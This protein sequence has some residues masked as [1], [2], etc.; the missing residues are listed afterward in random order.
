MEREVANR[1]IKAWRQLP[2]DLRSEPASEEQLAAFERTYGPIPAA[3]RW[4]LSECGG[5]V[6]GSEWVDH[7]EALAST[8]RKFRYESPDPK[9]WRMRGVFVIGWDGAGN[10]FGVDAD[11]G[12]VLVEDHSFGGIHEMAP[13]FEALL[14]RGVLGGA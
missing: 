6:V 7:I 2:E 13:S 5:G 11:T 1:I 8:H 3:V 10:P 14:I 12:K 4:F 9:G